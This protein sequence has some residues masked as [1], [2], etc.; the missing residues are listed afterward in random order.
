MNVDGTAILKEGQYVNAYKIGKHLGQ[1]D[2][3]VQVKPV[4]VIRDYDRNAVLDF[5]NGKETTGLYGINIHR[6]SAINNLQNVDKWSA[7]C[8]VWSRDADFEEFMTLCNKQVTLN[9]YKTFTYT[10]LVEE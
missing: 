9:G 8:Q 6:A 1:Y 10:L 2:A 3:L 7:G 4:T 5:N